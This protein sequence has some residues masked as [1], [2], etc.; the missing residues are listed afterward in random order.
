MHQ[1][2]NFR[3]PPC[4]IVE[5]GFILL[6]STLRARSPMSK[7]QRC[8][9]IPTEVFKNINQMGNSGFCQTTFSVRMA[10]IRSSSLAKLL[11]SWP[12]IRSTNQDRDS[13][14][15]F[16]SFFMEN[17]TCAAFFLNHLIRQR[18]H[19]H[20]HAWSIVCLFSVIVESRRIFHQLS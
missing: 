19:A 13:P 3:A 7:Y 6:F 14:S 10:F 9:R 4:V 15:K 20:A 16:L 8:M 12:I 18:S 2:A 17:K 11:I 1:R 5:V